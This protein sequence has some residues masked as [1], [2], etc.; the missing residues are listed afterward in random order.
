MWWTACITAATACAAVLPWAL[1][2]LPA[3]WKARVVGEQF[4]AHAAL[5]EKFPSLACHELPR[6]F[7][8]GRLFYGNT[9]A[10]FLAIAG[11]SFALGLASLAY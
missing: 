8:L 7:A 1:L 5:A 2:P 4:A 9:T 11:V 6:L 10:V 3:I